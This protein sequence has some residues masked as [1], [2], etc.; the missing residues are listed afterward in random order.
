MAATLNAASGGAVFPDLATC[1]ATCGD[2]NA[3]DAAVQACEGEADTFNGSGDNVSLPFPE[4]NAH[5]DPCKA[6][7][8]TACLIIDPTACAVQ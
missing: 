8:A 7:A 2:P 4:G 3:S 6:A 5:P 1:N